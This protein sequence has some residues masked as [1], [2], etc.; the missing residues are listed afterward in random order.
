MNSYFTGHT[1]T[2]ESSTATQEQ[3]FVPRVPQLSVAKRQRD[4][5]LNSEV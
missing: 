3:D 4:D 2:E 1:S 5:P